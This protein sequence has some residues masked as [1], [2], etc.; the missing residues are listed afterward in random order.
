M[1][2]KKEPF[3]SFLLD[4]LEF[5]HYNIKDFCFLNVKK[6]IKSQK[7]NKNSTKTLDKIAVTM[8][9]VLKCLH[10]YAIYVRNEVHNEKDFY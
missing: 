5:F 9:N 10:K 1:P 7:M 3:G 4:K 2:T 8:Y 6:C